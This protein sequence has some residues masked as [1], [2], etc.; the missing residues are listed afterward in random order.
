MAG[1]ATKARLWLPLESTGKEVG[2]GKRVC[3]WGGSFSLSPQAQPRESPVS[4]EGPIAPKDTSI[5]GRPAWGGDSK[6]SLPSN[7]PS[8]VP[9]ACLPIAQRAP[10]ED[11]AFHALASLCPG[12]IRSAPR[13]DSQS[14]LLFW[15]TPRSKWLFPQDEFTKGLG[16]ASSTTVTAES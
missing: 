15:T 11:L 6:A 12:I 4:R 13:P 9:V 2:R 3:V 10:G 1:S 7:N 14:T 16:N 5:P 8:T